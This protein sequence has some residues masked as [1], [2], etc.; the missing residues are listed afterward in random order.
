[1][2]NVTG[3]ELAAP[4]PFVTVTETELGLVRSAAGTF[5]VKDVGET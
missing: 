4:E 5:A 1:M 3:A 2:V